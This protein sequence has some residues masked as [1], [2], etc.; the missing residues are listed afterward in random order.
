MIQFKTARATPFIFA[1]V[2]FLA[3]CATSV[4]VSQP[5]DSQVQASVAVQEAAVQVA[6]GV[7]VPEGTEQ[8][9]IDAVM[10]EAG[11]R[12]AGETPVKLNMTITLWEVKGGGTRA[13]AGALAG[14]NKLDIA[15]EVVDASSGDVI[16]AY[17]V[18]RRA[19]PG[20]YGMFYD[21]AQGTIN[22]GA[23]GVVE[24]LFGEE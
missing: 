18:S 10:K 8:K 23:E 14:S 16:G 20:G 1:A 4:E 19:N 17:N 13:L 15:V 7:A 24:G 11:E 2:L 6:E 12:T 9:L 22:E 3:G 21:Q 5:I